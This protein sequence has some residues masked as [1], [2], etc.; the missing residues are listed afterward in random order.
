MLHFHLHQHISIHVP[1]VGHDIAKL[2]AAET[3]TDFNPRAPGGARPNSLAKRFRPLVFQSTCPRWGT[4]QPGL[5]P[6]HIFSDFNPR[7][8]GGARPKLFRHKEENTYFNPRA[9][10][11]ARRFVVPGKANTT[12]FQSTCPRWGTTLKRLEKQEVRKRISIHVPQVGHDYTRAAWLQARRIFQSTCPRW[13]TTRPKQKNADRMKDFN[14]RA[15]GGAR[16]YSVTFPSASTHFNPRAPGGAR[17]HSCRTSF[18]CL[19]FNPRAPGGA[20][21]ATLADVINEA[22]DISIHVPQVGH[23]LRPDWRSNAEKVIS[24]HVPQV[25]HDQMQHTRCRLWWTFQST[26]PRWGTTRPVQS[27]RG[28]CQFQSTCPRWGTT[29]VVRVF[30]AGNRFQSTCPRWGTTSSPI[31]QFHDR[32]ISIHVPQVGHDVSAGRI[33][34]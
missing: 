24:I 1:Q 21:P 10:G 31:A 12:R 30:C 34:A 9:P 3:E 7:A 33:S 20:R 32:T 14:P 15:P 5:F 11:G 27:W 16:R 28:T 23:D 19:D 4:T 25:G 6:L 18:Q 17:Q 2:C 26:C 8:P 29:R 22:V 13:G